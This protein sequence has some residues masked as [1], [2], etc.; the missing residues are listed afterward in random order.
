MNLKN[1]TP[2]KRAKPNEAFFLSFE[3]N[4]RSSTRS[5]DAWKNPVELQVRE[6]PLRGWLFGVGAYFEAKG[7]DRR[8]G[9]L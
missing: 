1:L 2:N 9:V 7:G 8:K 6:R 4:K 3:Q 5:L